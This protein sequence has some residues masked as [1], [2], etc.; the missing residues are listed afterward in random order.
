MLN[1]AKIST[2]H[3]KNWFHPFS[4]ENIPFGSFV[5]KTFYDDQSKLNFSFEAMCW[6][7]FNVIK[8][9]FWRKFSIK[10]VHGNNCLSGNIDNIPFKTILKLIFSPPMRFKYSRRLFNLLGETQRRHEPILIL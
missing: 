1:M 5:L 8:K 6:G 7:M 3:F 2:T 4:S 10:K 9:Y